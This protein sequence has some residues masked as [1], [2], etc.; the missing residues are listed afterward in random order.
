M[1]IKLFRNNFFGH[2]AS[3][4]VNRL[5]FEAHWVELTSA[6]R[7]LGLSQTEIDR[8]K[9]EECGKEEVNRVREECSKKEREI[10]SKIDQIEKTLREVHEV[11]YSTDNILNECLQWC[12]FEKEIQL[13]LERY[14][15]GTREWV[16]QQVSIWLNDTN[17]DNRA[18]I[19]S[20]QAGMGKSTIAAVLCKKSK[21]HFAACHFFQYND[22][23]Y[24]KPKFFLQSLAWQLC[25]VLPEYKQNLAS[26]LSG[27]EGQLLDIMNIEGLFTMLFKEPFTNIPDPSKHFLIVIDAIDESQ[28]EER[29]ELV[30]LIT[31]H[32]HKFPRFIRFLITTRSEKDIALKF[33]GLNP[34]LLEPDDERNL[35]DLRLFFEDKLGT[36]VEHASQEELVKNLVKKSEGLMLYASFLCR[37]SKDNSIQSNIESLPEGIEE[38]YESYFDR[39]EKELKILGIEEEKFLLLLSVIAV[40]QQPLPSAF[41]E[42][43][44]SSKRFLIGAKRMFSKLISCISSFLIIKDDCVS[45]FHKSVKDWLVKANHRFTIKEKH[46]HRTLAYICVFQMETLK[47]NEVRSPFDFAIAI[48]YALKYGIPH[49]LHAEIKDMHSLT[50]LIDYFTDLEIVHA[51]VCVDVYTTLRNFSSLASYNMHTCLCEETQETIRTVMCI[52][53]R[54]TYILKNVPQSFFQHIVNE[55]DDVLS[56]NASTLLMTRYRGLAYFESEDK[57]E[58]FE[59]AMIGRILTEN[60]VLDIDISPSDD[61]L[62][63]GYEKGVE[64]FS[65]SDF[66]P[67][68]KID[69]FVVE[70]S[71][72]WNNLALRIPTHILKPPRCIIFHP[73]KDII[74]PGQLTRVLNLAGNFESGLVCEEILNTFTHGC[75]SHDSTKMVTNYGIHL[76]VWNLLEN[77]KIASL[78]CRSELFSI[79]FSANDRFIGTT[80]IDEF[81]VYDTDNSY[82]IISRS[83][84]GFFAVI[85][86]T[87]YS[88]SWYCHKVSQTQLK[89]KHEIVKYDLTNKRVPDRFIQL[90]P[91]NAR[92]AAEFQAVVESGDRS[93][94]HEVD[95]D[96]FFILANK[97][98]L[99]SSYNEN[100]IKLFSHTE[101]IQN[102]NKKKQA[103]NL[104][105]FPQFVRSF[106]VSVDGRYIYT[107]DTVK[108][109]RVVELSSPRSVKVINFDGAED[110]F[111]RNTFFLPVT[112]GVFFCRQVPNPM[113][114]NTFFAGIPELWNFGVTQRLASFPEL[115]GTCHCLSIAHDLVACIM[116]LQVCF[117]NVLEKVIVARTPFP[118]HILIY[119]VRKNLKSR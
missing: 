14:T 61:F 107:D 15:E 101:L 89:T 59:K 33:Q 67:L 11:K 16:F 45:F 81:C 75:F 32:F 53:R 48:V 5:D 6:L 34:L 83:C 80:D 7:N 66:R 52:I 47:Q 109:F 37:L 93:W 69:N 100:E 105:F 49:M 2:V 111:I 97:S 117:F 113:G 28:Q 84:G 76:T 87:F 10:L 65:L 102:S 74:F 21:E 88:D 92:A 22:S 23:R 71:A 110:D 39:L 106:S 9:A 99:V 41:I 96:S 114:E 64:V 35:N 8:L 24:N 4:D 94:L 31:R 98:V 18:F 63:C 25:N 20:G 115:T 38:I 77:K 29:Y 36:K 70:R 116:E 85:V 58:N 19:I 104:S 55:N 12:D 56:S 13:L 40:A 103:F 17:S 42:R 78:S 54:F 57:K 79:L 46:G 27:N 1:L 112:N 43:L 26:K 51:S 62:I 118:E 90:L 73:V 68:W 86:S 91:T 3:T 119:Y 82:S 60:R 108:H 30:D 44:L 72:A 95:N 50:K